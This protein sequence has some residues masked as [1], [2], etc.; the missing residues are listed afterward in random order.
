MEAGKV[1]ITCEKINPDFKHFWV[2]KAYSGRENQ[3]IY[4]KYFNV[5]PKPQHNQFKLISTL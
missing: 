4:K 1:M 3:V 5:I 2:R